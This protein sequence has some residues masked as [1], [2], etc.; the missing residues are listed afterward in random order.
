MIE[1]FRIMDVVAC[2]EDY[3]REDNSEEEIVGEFNLPAQTLFNMIYYKGTY[4]VKIAVNMPIRIA[5]VDSW[6]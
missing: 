2:W 5:T 6:M 1:K 3:G 4:L